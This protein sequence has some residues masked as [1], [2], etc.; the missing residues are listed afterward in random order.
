MKVNRILKKITENWGAKVLCFILA[1]MI[2]MFHQTTIF[3]RKTFAVPLI[4]VANGSVVPIENH[5]DFV[6]VTV[7]TN[8]DQI[9]M[10]NEDTVTARIDLN[11]YVEEGAFDVPVS[12]NISHELRTLEPLE[13]KVKPE[14]IPIL[15]EKKLEEYIEI[16]A[17][18]TGNPAAGYALTGVSVSPS[19]TY[20]AGPSSIVSAVDR[21]KTEK[22]D[23]TGVSQNTRVISHLKNENPYLKVN[24]ENEV[25][26]TYTVEPIQLTRHFSNIP[27]V[28][29]NLS[30]DFTLSAPVGSV[31]FD[32][33][34]PELRLANY[35]IEENAVYINC[36]EISE[37]GSY[38]LPVRFSLPVGVTVGAINAD[39]IN[40]TVVLSENAESSE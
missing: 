2:Y 27:V 25:V 23:I 24:T 28:A 26:V 10:L 38:D 36:V 8:A 7:R 33:R 18:V 30:P 5:P 22:I 19:T 35:S 31:S 3:S 12:I 39:I 32:L 37:P 29:R 16:E 15:L 6:R 1:I 17:A 40:V 9:S 4:V 20:V 34:G 11:A 21:I 14:Y 13:I